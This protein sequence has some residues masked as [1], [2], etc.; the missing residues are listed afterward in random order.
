MTIGQSNKQEA[1]QKA[2]DLWNQFGRESYRACFRRFKE[3]CLYSLESTCAA[4]GF[5]IPAIRV[6]VN[7]ACSGMALAF[8]LGFK[9]GSAVQQRES[10]RTSIITLS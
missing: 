10:K 6:I 2:N 4:M 3:G 9:I 5:P 8:K 7:I 1:I